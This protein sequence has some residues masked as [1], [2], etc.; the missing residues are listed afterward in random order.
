MSLAALEQQFDAMLAR[1]QQ[2]EARV[3][4]AGLIDIDTAPIRET[5]LRV[6]AAKTAGPLAS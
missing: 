2:P 4:A 1:L 3:T 6:A 5:A